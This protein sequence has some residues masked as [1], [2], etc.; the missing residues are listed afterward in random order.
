MILTWKKW[1]TFCLIAILAFLACQFYSETK[2]RDFHYAPGLEADDY[3]SLETHADYRYFKNLVR[4][5]TGLAHLPWPIRFGVGETAQ[6]FDPARTQ[7]KDPET[8]MGLAILGPTTADAESCEIVGCQHHHSQRTEWREW[9]KRL[10]ELAI[11]LAD[12]SAE[13]QK[14]KRIKLFVES[15]A[16]FFVDEPTNQPQGETRDTDNGFGETIVKQA[17]AIDPN[18]LIYSWFEVYPELLKITAER[19]GSADLVR[20]LPSE[21]LEQFY[22]LSDE[23]TL[24]PAARAINEHLNK[25][26]KGGRFNAFQTYRL[27]LKEK[28]LAYRYGT[29]EPSKL[30]EPDLILASQ[31]A[32]LEGVRDG[33]RRLC[34]V[35][36]KLAERGED[37]LALD[38]Y[39]HAY[40][41]C[42]QMM[43]GEGKETAYP[44]F[45]LGR[46]GTTFV[47]EHLM[48]FWA[49]RGDAE[50]AMRA[51]MRLDADQ[52]LVKREIEQTQ[53]KGSDPLG[54]HEAAYEN[55]AR[56]AGLTWW[57]GTTGIFFAVVSL[58]GVGLYILLARKRY[59]GDDELHISYKLLEVGLGVPIF[60][61]VWL[62]MVMPL[63]LENFYATGSL[64][65]W[66]WMLILLWL[67]FIGLLALF[68]G[69]ETE[70]IR[71]SPGRRIWIFTSLGVAAAC[72]VASIISATM[73]A[74]IAVG[75]SVIVIGIGFFIWLVVVMICWLMRR[76]HA[77]LVSR[78]RANL[79]FTVCS[80][81]A[82]AV[83]L[84]AALAS[85]PL[86]R[87]QQDRYFEQAT[88]D[89][90]TETGYC[91][92]EEWSMTA[93]A[94]PAEIFTIEKT[95]KP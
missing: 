58:I 75:I 46:T 74:V 84:I 45:E 3:F 5:M 4:N 6:Q 61:M 64:L 59:L 35:G 55:Y 48:A 25:A 32:H 27:L 94:L 16:N 40:R 71:R 92:G 79:A 51:K 41:V 14:L 37:K 33:I 24:L 56:S 39:R 12:D 73:S 63:D 53:K 26:E 38:M 88:S 91:A 47:S 42:E 10:S 67:I 31:L 89:I 11:G 93:K 13:R 78:A 95:V 19:A 68:S 90:Q 66:Q 43:L 60:L 9:F 36:G 57:L 15:N 83:F 86:T 28:G 69:S 22:T 44:Q 70:G 87:Y 52:L 81:L 80:M 30:R 21:T 29:A 65:T 85:M 1:T 20:T 2:L 49:G 17:H 7:T 62:T 72:I 50:K 8:I 76:S 54:H 77:D 18:N 23:A 34:F 82:S